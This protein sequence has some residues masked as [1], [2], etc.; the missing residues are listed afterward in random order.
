MS[1]FLSS[2]PSQQASVGGWGEPS[3]LEAIRE[4]LHGWM[5]VQRL[6]RL[7]GI[8]RMIAQVHRYISVYML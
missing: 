2:L 1:Y 5:H 4:G 3:G 6:L 8:G 7:Q